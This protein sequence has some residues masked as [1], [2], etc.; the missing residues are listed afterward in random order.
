[1]VTIIGRIL[2]LC[3]G[4]GKAPL[5]QGS[6]WC[7]A[8]LYTTHYA[9]MLKYAAITQ[10]FH[11]AHMTIYIVAKNNLIIFRKKDTPS[12][13]QPHSIRNHLGSHLITNFVF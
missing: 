4:F 5:A 10:V 7:G 2:I 8:E 9:E 1:M 6:L 13:Y 3:I 12:F 11:L